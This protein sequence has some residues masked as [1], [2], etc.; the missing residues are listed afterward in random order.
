[1]GGTLRSLAAAT[2]ATG[3]PLSNTS[4]APRSNSS[5]GYFLGRG[6]RGSSTSSRTDHLGFEVSVRPSL[7]QLDPDVGL[8]AEPD[9][10]AL[11]GPR[12]PWKSH[13]RRLNQRQVYLGKGFGQGRKLGR[14]NRGDWHVRWWRGKLRGVDARKRLAVRA[15]SR[16]AAGAAAA[17][18]A[19]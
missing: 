19:A 17:G 12:E 1:M 6:I 7:A 14:L 16:A 18:A 4:R 8:G 11:S 9:S 13:R 15:G 3:R 2:C 5:G 10:P